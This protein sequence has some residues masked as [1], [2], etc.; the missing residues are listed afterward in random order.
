VGAEDLGVFLVAAQPFGGIVVAIPL[1][2]LVLGHPWWWWLFLGPLLAYVQV[3]VIDL[4]FDLLMRWPW[5][6]RLLERHRSARVERMMAS[7]GGFW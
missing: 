5:W 7:G 6:R 1:A 3:P 4:F 2:V